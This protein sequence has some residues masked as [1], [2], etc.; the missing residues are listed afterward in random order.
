[1]S[2]YQGDLLIGMLVFVRAGALLSAVPVF[3]G[4]AVPVQLRVALSLMIAYLVTPLLPKLGALPT[5]LTMLVI[6]AVSELLVG[7]LMGLAVR[8][9]FSTIDFASHII[10][11]ESG[12]MRADSIS[13][14]GG[15]STSTIGSLLFYFGTLIFMITGLHY[16]VI[17]AF[18]KSF[19]YLSPGQF[20]YTG[21]AI[22]LLIRDTTRIF[23]VGLQMGAPV[24]AVNFIVNLTFAVLGK[25]APKVNV[26]LTSFAVRI[27]TGLVIFLSTVGL[28]THYIT[29]QGQRAPENMLRFLAF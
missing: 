2:L 18:V 26:F 13:P 21:F 29:M 23:M 5:H 6:W 20:L 28:I 4:R 12:L 9:V 17:M 3:A 8:I 7:I 24:I 16:Q 25:A 15:S 1:M 11:Q 27:V 19:Q 14:L 22:D 10:S